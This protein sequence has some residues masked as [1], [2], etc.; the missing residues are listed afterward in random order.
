MTENGSDQALSDEET[1]FE[2]EFES[3][4]NEVISKPESLQVIRPFLFRSTIS[5]AVFD[6]D[7]DIVWSDHKFHDW[8]EADALNQDILTTVATRQTPDHL[9]V[10]DR[11]GR[12]VLLTIAPANIAARWSN[13]A[14]EIVDH[15]ASGNRLGIAAL[16]LGHMDSEIE[17]AARALG[18][19]NLEARVSAALFAYGSIKRAAIHAGV[20]Y[21][22]ARK[23]LTGAMKTVGVSRQT[24][25]IR[26][27]SQVATVSELP[28]D[29]VESIMIDVFSL[30]RRDAQLVHLLCEGYSRNDAA[31]IVGISSAV[32]KDR[33]AAAFQR[34]EID[35]ATDLPSVVLGAFAAA[36]LIQDTPPIVHAERR[37]LA[38][39]RL[40]PAA[41]GRMIA[42]NDYGPTLGRPVL[43]AHSSLSTRHPFLKFVRSLQSS[44]F[45]PFTIDRPGFGLTGDLD[46][47][48][49]R[50]A[51]GVDD[52]AKVCEALNLQEIDIVTRGGAFH[53]L[54]V[55]RELSHQIGRI[56]VINPDLLQHDCSERKGHLGLVRHAF[57][58]Y[59]DSIERVARWSSSMLSR[60]RIET[61]IRAGIGD[62]MAD[63]ASFEDPEN[64]NDYHR[65][66][67][68]FSTGNLSGF[69]R[70]QRGYV[71]QTEIEGLSNA[72]NW[73]VLLGGSDPIHDVDE[74][75]KFWS[76]KLP[77]SKLQN[78]PDAGRYISL[79]HTD[80][81]VSE[82][83]SR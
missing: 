39:L 23:A 13:F 34:L 70:E 41:D 53:V 21:H 48:P 35:S 58:R 10:K 11:S 25:L 81:V 83:S 46:E 65:S 74:I 44:G 62:A 72:E 4:L 43:I 68:A 80:L 29:A 20:T 32:A 61:I 56:V 22:T 76:K 19:S 59:P 66:I 54:A 78:V 8:V 9:L 69:I 28:R 6:I 73:T 12:L 38:P 60:K 7:D 14:S 77:G 30:K 42:V 67:M 36:V 33:F 3:R 18:M 82:L 52:V 37:E 57:D 63:L 24:S 49:D 79:S 50:F 64:F 5:L 31:R 17:R 2:A 47:L 15:L 71:L 75:W 51:T 1:L 16:S 55:A 27:L 26:K 40:I 45:R